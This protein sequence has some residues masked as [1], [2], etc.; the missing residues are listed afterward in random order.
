MAGAKPSDGKVWLVAPAADAK[1]RKFTVK[2]VPAAADT[3]LRAGMSA[4]VKIQ[5]GQQEKAVLV[6]KDAV[7][8][9][10]GQHIVFIDQ[11]GRAKLVTVETGLT[12]ERNVQILRGIEPAQMVILPGSIDLADGDAVQAASTA[13]AAAPAS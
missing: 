7:I 12:D 2:L 8:Q 13:P 11:A 4:T 9:R 1:T 3:S 6:P 10:N 5:T